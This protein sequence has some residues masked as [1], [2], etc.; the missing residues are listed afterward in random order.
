MSVTIYGLGEGQYL[1]GPDFRVENTPNGGATGSQSFLMLRSS[2]DGLRA[3]GQFANGQRASDLDE[4]TASRGG[5]VLSVDSVSTADEPLGMLR[6]TV[7]YAGWSA[8]YDTGEN[9]REP[10]PTYTK[11]GALVQRSI[12]EH[13]KVRELGEADRQAL[14]KVWDGSNLWDEGTQKVQVRVVDSDGGETY[15]DVDVQPSTTAAKAWAREISAGLHT[16]EAAHVVWEKTWESDTGVPNATASNL[17]KV[18]TPD[19]DPYTP[20]GRDWRLDE[21]SETR[22]GELYRNRTFHTLSEEGGWEAVV[23]DY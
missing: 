22:A 20:S 23:Y 21:V 1:P 4:N 5:D 10:V 2:W 11:R 3:Q 12:L 6:V 18:D 14:A 16:Y 15:K 8:S 19:G 9:A 17:G 7:R 13:P